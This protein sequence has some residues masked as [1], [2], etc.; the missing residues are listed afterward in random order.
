[1]KKFVL[2]ISLCLFMTGHVLASC[3]DGTELTGENG[4]VYCRSNIIMNWYSAFT[5]CEGHGRPLATMEQMCDIDETQKWEGAG[6]GKCLNLTSANMSWSATPYGTGQA[7]EL[8]GQRVSASGRSG[9]M[10]HALCW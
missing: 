9:N 4:H 8:Y 7:F 2:Y 5:W 10:R 3:V 1:M 6:E